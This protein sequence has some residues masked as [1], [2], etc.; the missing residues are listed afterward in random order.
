VL[1]VGHRGGG[2]DW[3]CAVDGFVTDAP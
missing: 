1:A 3:I 2:V